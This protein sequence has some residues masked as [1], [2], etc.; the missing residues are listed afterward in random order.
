[1]LWLV[2][3]AM[4]APSAD[5]PAPEWQL[6]AEGRA[7]AEEL[8]QSLPRVARVISSPEPKAVGTAEPIAR[9]CG[10]AV[11]VDERLRE[12]ERPTGLH[13]DYQERVRSYLGG[14]PLDGWEPREAARARV[15]AA[16]DGLDDAVAV[17]HGLAISLY[18]GDDFDRWRA[19]RFPD[20][21]QVAR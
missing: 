10:I 14:E 11:E 9:A 17:S 3:H 2:R 1:M 8:A 6:T 12:V 18:L 5:V 7:D 16:L 15:A 13:T 21:V 19:L 4:V 20:V